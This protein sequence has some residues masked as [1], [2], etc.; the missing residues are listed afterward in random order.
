MNTAAADREYGTQLAA[1]YRFFDPSQ[2]LVQQLESCRKNPEAEY[3]RALRFLGVRDDYTPPQ[4]R[5]TRSPRHERVFEALQ[6]APLPEGTLDAAIGRPPSDQPSGVELW[7]D[8]ERALHADLDAEIRE[9]IELAP[10]LDL[11]LWPE[12]AHLTRAS[13]AV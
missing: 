2:V 13:S 10:D 12:F 8:I 4:H 3:K 7:P 9:L 5:L 1:L 11:S 6:K